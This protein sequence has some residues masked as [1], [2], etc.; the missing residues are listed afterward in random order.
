MKQFKSLPVLLLLLLTACS[1]QKLPI[2]TELGSFTAPEVVLVQGSTFTM[3]CTDEQASDCEGDEKPAHRVTLSSF[4][5]GKYEVTV[6]E[7]Y[8]YAQSTGI[9]M[10]V[11]P[12]WDWT[13]GGGDY[14]IVNVNWFDAARYC[15]WLSKK[16]GLTQVYSFSG[17]DGSRIAIS[18]SANGY[19]LP[20]EAE[21]EYAARGGAKSRGYKYS[22]SNEINKVAWYDDNTFSP[23]AYGTRLPNELD[24][25]DMN[26][27]VSEWCQDW[28]SDTYYDMSPSTDPKGPERGDRRVL[29][30][31]GWYGLAELLRVTNRDDISPGGRGISGGFRVARSQ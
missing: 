23:K 27:N 26:G 16:E 13:A 31:G 3:G 12:G 22:G 11:E 29:R 17:I 25:Y 6:N 7:Y 1:I 18:H 10:P 14:P 9:D 20:T 2:H 28:Y 21:W 15:N 30:G 19:R 24:L 4:Y 8:D 5:I